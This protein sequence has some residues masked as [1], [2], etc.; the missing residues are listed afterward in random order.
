MGLVCIQNS[1]LLVYSKCQALSA[2]SAYRF[3]TAEG[4][5]DVTVHEEL[6]LVAVELVT[7][8]I[9]FRDDNFPLLLDF[10]A[11]FNSSLEKP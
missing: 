4:D 2:S 8:E 10:E 1:S 11:M 3:S 5:D 6:V 7:T 9:A